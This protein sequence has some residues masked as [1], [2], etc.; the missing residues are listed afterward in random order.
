MVKDA[1]QPVKLKS[2]LF[3]ALAR[4]PI[5]DPFMDTNLKRAFHQIRN[6]A[7]FLSRYAL[8]YQIYGSLSTI[9]MLAP[10]IKRNSQAG[11]AEALDIQNIDE[12]SQGTVLERV[13]ALCLRGYTNNQLLRDIDAASMTHSLEVRV[14]YLDPLL[15][16]ISLSLP[17]ESKLFPPKVVDEFSPAPANTYRSLGA[18]RIL[19]DVGRPLLPEGFDIQPKRG[20]AMPFNEWLHGPLNE[21]YQDTLSESTVKKRGWF[22]PQEVNRVKENFDSYTID[23]LY[24]WLLIMTELWAREVLDKN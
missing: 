5:F 21:V 13:T 17:D 14:P 20:F 10:E 18:K 4:Q 15:A 12:L 8:Q 11:R 19:I 22:N 1:K 7:G 3:A 24:P 9:S 16:D 6:S 23:W 2:R